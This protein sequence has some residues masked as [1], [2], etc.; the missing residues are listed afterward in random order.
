MAA[1]RKLD[2]TEASFEADYAPSHAYWGT[3]GAFLAKL[4]SGGAPE[5]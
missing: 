5:S 2:D 4:L 1:H 3:P